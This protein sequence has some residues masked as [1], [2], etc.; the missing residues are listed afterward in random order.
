MMRRVRFGRF[1][2]TL[3]ELLVV[4]AVI[5]ILIALLL[6]AVQKVREAANRTKC[7]N[8]LRQIGLAAQTCQD[9]YK[10]LPPACGW[11]P[12]PAAQAGYPGVVTGG[13][14]TFWHLL[15]FL[16]E[17]VEYNLCWK[18]LP[19]GT[20]YSPLPATTVLP[21][22]VYC[23]FYTPDI[24]YGTTQITRIPAFVCPS[25]P[26][27]TMTGISLATSFGTGSEGLISYVLNVQVFGTCGTQ[28]S[29]SGF[30][31]NPGNATAGQ[32]NAANWNCANTEGNARI[33]TTF[34][35]GTSKTILFAERYANCDY[36]DWGVGD[37]WV[38]PSGYNTK[39]YIW[40]YN[41]P[42]PFFAFQY[43]LNPYV[44]PIPYWSPTGGV[45][46]WAGFAWPADW[47]LG[48]V[49]PNSRFQVL[50]S[51]GVSN[52][53]NAVLTSTGHP[54]GMQV[55]LADGSAHNLNPGMSGNTWWALC[56]PN[57]NDLVGTDWQE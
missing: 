20:P 11:F 16:E 21:A 42:Q 13:G 46:W 39:P 36:N 57:G 6:P 43:S 15:P 27:M 30:S 44:P 51:P 35:D 34:P 3:V 28:F 5:A 49:G 10:S 19:P 56:T 4:I 7:S 2:F 40:S 8:N 41:K 45:A 14:N 32:S 48:G 9:A 17:T 12:M 22:G 23:G 24:I 29:V 26:T 31:A 37:E 47:P 55:S 1:G 50:P 38:Y 54:A 52:A 33:P 18:P 25:D 53:C